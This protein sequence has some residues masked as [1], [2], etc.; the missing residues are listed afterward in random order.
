MPCTDAAGIGAQRQSGPLEVPAERSGPLRMLTK[1][2]DERESSS[3]VKDTLGTFNPVPFACNNGIFKE[4]RRSGR[5][6]GITGSWQDSLASSALRD[7]PLHRLT[8]GCKHG[9][10]SD[11]TA[12]ALNDREP[13]AVGS[14]PVSATVPGRGQHVRKIPHSLYQFLS[15]PLPASRWVHVTGTECDGVARETAQPKRWPGPHPGPADSRSSDQ[16]VALG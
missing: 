9:S 15:C 14:S 8:L 11:S 2:M 16:P 10:V 6:A 1:F 13:H 7:I 4:R 5:S 12:S 3:D